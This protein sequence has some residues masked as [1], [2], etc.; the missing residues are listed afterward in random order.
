VTL[1]ILFIPRKHGP[2]YLRTH[3]LEHLFPPNIL[4]PSGQIP[5]PLLDIRQLLLISTLDLRRLTDRQVEVEADAV[6]MGREPTRVTLV[7][8]PEANTVFTRVASREREAALVATLL[9]HHPVVVIERLVDRDQQCQ[10]VVVAVK[11]RV[12]LVFLRL[13]LAFAVSAACWV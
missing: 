12:R 1:P 4:Q 5:N 3:P 11:V 6:R 8:R 2:H 13:V 10:L 9:V 7:G